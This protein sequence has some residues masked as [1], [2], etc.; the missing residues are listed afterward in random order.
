METHVKAVELKELWRRCKED[1]DERA[2]ERLVVAYS[3][4]VIESIG[5]PIDSAIDS[6]GRYVE[7]LVPMTLCTLTAI[8][9]DDWARLS[10]A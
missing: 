7:L 6:D 9:R 1:G 3:P 8:D 10:H 4:L 5:Q 2:R